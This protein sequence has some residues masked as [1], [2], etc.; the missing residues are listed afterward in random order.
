MNDSINS[1]RNEVKRLQRNATNKLGRLSKQFNRDFKG[2]VIDPRKSNESINKYNRKQLN[3]QI[4]RLKEFNK[5]DGTMVPIGKNNELIA[6]T[7]WQQLKRIEK[8]YNQQKRDV[9]NAVKDIE[10]IPFNPVKQHVGMANTDVRTIG[11]SIFNS[12]VETNYGLT[13]FKDKKQFDKFVDELNKKKERGMFKS[14]IDSIKASLNGMARYLD[15]NLRDV[16]GESFTDLVNSLNDNQLFAVW[17]SGLADSVGLA[18]SL[19]YGRLYDEYTLSDRAIDG[20]LD[21]E[22]NEIYNYVSRARKL[23]I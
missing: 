15:G 14:S 6:V 13:R 2:S 23:V 12:F 22:T 16:N 9:Y 20:L 17:N 5:R 7:K 8:N 19:I 11:R 21:N 4:D 3:A 10:V 18:Y 1:L